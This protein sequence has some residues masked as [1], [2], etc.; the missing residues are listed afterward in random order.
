LQQLLRHMDQHEVVARH[1]V[2]QH[3]LDPEPPGAGGLRSPRCLHLT[4][5][6]PSVKKITSLKSTLE[7]AF[8]D[9]VG[10]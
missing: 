4:A 5:V 10:K 6:D 1:D 2:A 7:L 3:A 8:I 9:P